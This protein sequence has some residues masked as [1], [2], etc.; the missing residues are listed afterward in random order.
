MMDAG[1]ARCTSPS[2]DLAPDK[3][4]EAESFVRTAGYLLSPQPSALSPQPSALSPQPSA[5]SPQPPA[6]PHAGMIVG[7]GA[8]RHGLNREV[9]LIQGNRP[10]IPPRPTGTDV[11]SRWAL[12]DFASREHCSAAS[13]PA[14]PHAAATTR[15]G[16]DRAGGGSCTHI[17]HTQPTSK[18]PR[19]SVSFNLTFTRNDLP[20]ASWWGKVGKYPIC[21]HL[22]V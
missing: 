1:P 6:P 15:D 17:V 19:A 2:G 4:A 18:K 10:G 12:P 21:A 11:V 7:Y 22:S 9:R 5:L 8:T 3:T 16:R 14:R 13:A 20:F